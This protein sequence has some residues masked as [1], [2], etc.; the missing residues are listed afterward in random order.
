MAIQKNRANCDFSWSDAQ[1]RALSKAYVALLDL[2]NNPGAE[3]PDCESRVVLAF[4]L[5][6]EMASDL[7][8]MYDA[9]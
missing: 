5:S 8:N 2:M 9:E 1:W 4:N 3:Y 7:R 6:D